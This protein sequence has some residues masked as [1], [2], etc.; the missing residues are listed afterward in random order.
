MKPRLFFV[1]LIAVALIL[2][3]AAALAQDKE[4]SKAVLYNIHQDKVIPS[5]VEKYEKAAKTL[6]GA[7]SQHNVSGLS[8]F[9]AMRNDFTYQYVSEAENM[10]DLDKSNERWGELQKKMGKENFDAAMSAFDGCYES[11]KNFLVWFRPDLS[12]N[13]EYGMKPEDGMPFRQW[14]FYHIHTGMESQAEAIAKEWVALNK[15]LKSP[16]GYRFM[17][18]ALGTDGPVVAVISPGKS[19][20]DIYARRDE[21]RKKSGAEGEALMKKTWSIV[22]KHE[23]SNGMIRPDLSVYPKEMAKQ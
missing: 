22:R 17:V 18:G 7:A 14:N 12:Y 19:I 10:A 20:A 2:T 16:D 1:P 8:Y 21:W 5:M 13:P 9:A 23:T 4:K 6:A 11:H 3:A 15:K